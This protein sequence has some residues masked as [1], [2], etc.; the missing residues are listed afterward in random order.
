M[1]IEPGDM[2][3]VLTDDTDDSYCT[4]VIVINDDYAIWFHNGTKKWMHW[5]TTIGSRICVRLSASKDFR[6]VG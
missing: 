2:F 6:K 4:Y 1:N 5:K 3:E